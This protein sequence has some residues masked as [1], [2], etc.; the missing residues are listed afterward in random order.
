MLK[1]LKKYFT[2]NK[3][4]VIAITSFVLYI[5][6]K[7]GNKY[8]PIEEIAI[9]SAIGCDVENIDEE[10]LYGVSLAIYTYLNGSVSSIVFTG[11]ANTVPETRGTRQVQLTGKFLLGLEK[12][13]VISDKAARFGI[14]NFLE[15]LWVNPTINDN[16]YFVVSK[17]KTEDILNFNV[18]GHN[19]S[20]DYIDDLIKHL[21]GFNFY[22]E[23]YKMIDVMIRAN[24][25]GRSL[26]LPYIEIKDDKLKV[27]GMAL[28]KKDKLVKNIE[29]EEAR[30]MNLLRESNVNGIVELKKSPKSYL[31]FYGTSKRTV[32]CKKVGDKFKFDIKLKIKGTVSSNS[33]YKNLVKNPEVKKII[34]KDL[35]KEVEKLS[36][37]FIEK[38][39][40]DYEVDCLEL[41]RCAVE[42]YGRRK[43]IDWDQ[44]VSESEINVSADVKVVEIGRGDL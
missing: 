3:V 7:A 13:V 31:S 5:Y 11:K 39:Q 34:E 44:V 2:N 20:G 23:N 6:C 9:P 19:S 10:T 25:E 8:V 26:V 17:E 12:V 42:K 30:T 22:S 28:F 14:K 4:L 16:A 29:L 18:K 37:D 43:N 21:V 40:N 15:A 27:T 38:M 35:K 32:E 1:A 41:G 36:Y 33:M 24:S